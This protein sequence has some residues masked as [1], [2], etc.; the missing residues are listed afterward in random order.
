MLTNSALLYKAC[1]L[2]IQ[3]SRAAAAVKLKGN[4]DKVELLGC[5]SDKESF[6]D[7]GEKLTA[8]LL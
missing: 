8:V 4:K 6:A 5:Y 2:R 3:L 7:T 1:I